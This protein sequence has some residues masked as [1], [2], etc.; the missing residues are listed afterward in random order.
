MIEMA[1]KAKQ[2]KDSGTKFDLDSDHGT[3]RI[4]VTVPEEEL[5]KG[6]EAQRASMVAAVSKRV[7]G[8]RPAT[9]PP[10][11]PPTAPEVTQPVL[12]AAAPP[13]PW[14]VPVAPKPAARA[15]T[16][17]PD[18]KAQIVT[19]PNGDTLFVKLPGSR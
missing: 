1:I 3:L 15:E 7:P 9:A 8:A 11:A 12:E 14:L 10:T 19:A 5:R 2:P 6:I 17:R 16:R 4:A 18:A 13:A